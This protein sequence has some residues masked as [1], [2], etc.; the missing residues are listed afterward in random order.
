MLDIPLIL[1]ISAILVIILICSFAYKL[2]I[3]LKH[4]RRLENYS[5]TSN[6]DHFNLEYKLWQFIHQVT[7]F[8]NNFF[9][10]ENISKKYEKYCLNNSNIKSATDFIS[11]KILTSL[12]FLAMYLFTIA[13]HSLNY[14]IIISIFIL[15]VG[16]FLPDIFLYLQTKNE[17]KYIENDLLKALI[18]MINS[19]KVNMSMEQTIETVIM[20]VNN[21]L[22]KEFIHIDE[23]IKHGLSIG[24]A[25][26]RFYER[27]KIEEVL[28]LSNILSLGNKNSLSLIDTLNKLEKD[29]V[30]KI[31][32]Q[33]ELSLYQ[34]TNK[35]IK[36][37][38]SIMPLL[39]ITFL[40]Y[41]DKDI[42]QL[43]LISNKSYLVIIIEII[44]YFVYL[45]LL[46]VIVRSKHYEW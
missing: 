6:N 29:L 16:Y 38:L 5:L 17:K 14:N 10:F 22:K 1:K 15:C 46:K 33:K 43:L 3:S 41:L 28:Y 11:I 12:I 18:I 25:V 24:S 34:N 36:Q 40:A 7:K 37:I 39:I 27:T 31:Q 32:L 42:M 20:Q 45:W 9:S 4:T 13:L 19:L 2:F 8:L 21:P 30:A 23:D 35:I 44:I 26:K